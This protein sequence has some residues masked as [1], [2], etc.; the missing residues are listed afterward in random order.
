MADDMPSHEGAPNRGGARPARAAAPRTSAA[1]TAADTLRERIFAIGGDGAF[2]GSEDDLLL[3]LGV[4]RPTLRQAARIL[5]H[6]HLLLV[7]RGANGG[8]FTR[9]PTTEAVARVASV[10]LRSRA[11]RLHDNFEAARLL[12]PEIARLAAANPDADERARFAAFAE[13]PAHAALVGDR[14][15]MPDV[16]QEFGRRLVALVDNPP[17]VLFYEVVLEVALAPF[18]VRVFDRANHAERALRYHRELGRAVRP[19][20]AAAAALAA[21]QYFDTIETWFADVTGREP[22]RKESRDDGF[23]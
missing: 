14:R 17:L 9:M 11:T 18:E 21:R 19:G 20:D 22:R 10:Y 16:I 3:A 15:F 6:E 7:R 2:L 23:S 12:A 1:Q 5:E 13:D 8:F 4:S